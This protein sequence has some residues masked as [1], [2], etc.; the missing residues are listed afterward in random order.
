MSKIDLQHQ[1]NALPTAWCSSIVGT[2]GGA[3]LKVLRMDASAYPTEVHDYV[4]ALLVLDGQMNL[5]IF[6]EII[7][8]GAGQVFI[9]PIGQ[10][11]SVAPGSH[12]TL[13]IVDQ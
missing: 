5:E 6:G 11:H 9:V 13:L 10:A 2:P 7:K 12:G 3:N 4:E 8:V 1:A